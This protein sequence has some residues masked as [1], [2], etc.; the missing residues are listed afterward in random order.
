MQN[1]VIEVVQFQAL[2]AAAEE[3]LSEAA[4]AA[5]PAIE[6]LP[7]YVSRQFGR[8]ESGQWID[9]VRWASMAHAQFAA[10]HAGRTPEVAAFFALIDMGSVRM[11]HYRAP[12]PAALWSRQPPARRANL[13]LVVE[14]FAPVRRFYEAHFNARALFEGDCYLVLQLGG[15]DA[16]ELHLMHP[17]SNDAAR[18]S[19]A[20]IMLN[21]QF[22]EVDRLHA[23]LAGSGAE[24]KMPLA[25]HPWGD[26]AFS[27][28]DPLGL[29]L[30]CYSPRPMAPEFAAGQRRPWAL[31]S[32][33]AEEVG[34]DVLETA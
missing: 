31:D 29:E 8:D 14:H 6:A 15:P 2:D 7:G 5:Q 27:V 32:A 19:G 1:D 10:K 21:L 11:N 9:V 17:S 20:G 28:L 23:E 25:D 22:D 3:R 26:R 13:T 12:A 16:P 18:A 33:P 24:L 30:Y 34:E 4:W